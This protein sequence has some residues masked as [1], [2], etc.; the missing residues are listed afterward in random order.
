[1]DLKQNIGL[2]V[3]FM[4]TTICIDRNNTICIIKNHGFHS[5]TKY[6]EIIHHFIREC[7][8]KGL[9]KMVKIHTDFNVADLLIKVF[10]VSMFQ[11][12]GSIGALNP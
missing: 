7:N 10:D 11:Y 12:C 3:Q 6:I 9:I 5:K 8:E 1:M 4:H 2:W